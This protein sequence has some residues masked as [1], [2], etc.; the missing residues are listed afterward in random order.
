MLFHLANSPLKC[1]ISLRQVLTSSFKSNKAVQI[2]KNNASLIYDYIKDKEICYSFIYE[3]G[4]KS[5]S[6][7]SNRAPDLRIR[8]SDV[9]Q[10]SCGEFCG[11]PAK[12][13]LRS[14]VTR[15]WDTLDPFESS[16]RQ[17]SKHN[18]KIITV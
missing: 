5:K 11:E 17:Q 3:N 8:R 2:P 9:L 7:T 18:G 6:L 12:P 13:L 16:Y 1:L 15:V 10:I 14:N 4:R